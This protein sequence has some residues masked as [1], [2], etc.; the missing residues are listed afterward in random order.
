MQNFWLTLNMSEGQFGYFKIKDA[1]K[2]EAQKDDILP[3]QRQQNKIIAYLEMGNKEVISS[4]KVDVAG[5]QR[6]K[7]LQK[8]A[9]GEFGKSKF[10]G[11]LLNIKAPIDNERDPNNPVELFDSVSANNQMKE[12]IAEFSKG[13]FKQV[14]NLTPKDLAAFLQK[15]PEPSDFEKNAQ[16]FLGNIKKKLSTKTPTIRIIYEPINA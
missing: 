9:K 12:L 8:V 13:D 15:Y 5:E 16:K 6:Q 14:D 11:L 10:R 3:N 1:D 7:F 4:E 2:K